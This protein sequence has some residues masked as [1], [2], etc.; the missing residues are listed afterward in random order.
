MYQSVHMEPSN[1]K[2]TILASI[3][4]TC[5]R[6]C[7]FVAYIL[8]KSYVTLRSRSHD[9]STMKFIDNER[10]TACLILV[11]IL[12]LLNKLLKMIWKKTWKK[13]LVKIFLCQK[14]C[15]VKVWS[16]KSIKKY[17]EKK[18]K[19]TTKQLPRG[20]GSLAGVMSSGM[21]GHIPPISLSIPPWGTSQFHQ[22][23][24]TT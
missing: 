13:C 12:W 7:L 3:N 6:A 14:C 20:Q 19:R 18:L 9:I 11:T 8:N 5:K 22:A 4:Y 10:A 21:C 15:L 24:N 1:R 16:K 17:V 2:V 23:L